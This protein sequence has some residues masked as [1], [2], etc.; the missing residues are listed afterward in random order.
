MFWS[1]SITRTPVLSA[2]DIEE[3]EIVKRAR[4]GDRTAF[5]K[6]FQRYNAGICTYL[7][8]KVGNDEDGRDLAQD[9]FLKAWQGLPGLR[10]VMHFKSWLYRIATNLAHDHV[11]R[12]RNY[13]ILLRVWLL[14]NGAS[15]G[16]RGSDPEEIAAE[17]E[18]INQALAALPSKFRDSLL[19]Q[20]VAGFSQREIAEIL[21][22]DEKSVATY[23]CNGRKR[24]REAYQR[25]ESKRTDD[26]GSMRRRRSIQ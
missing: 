5:E 17:A 1:V 8:H 7:A 4:A 13:H 26:P 3:P 14:E 16:A 20:H 21:D 15:E 2:E 24:F 22:I 9:T 12:Q 23:T 11:R 10:D 18:H 25:I 19:L 6:L